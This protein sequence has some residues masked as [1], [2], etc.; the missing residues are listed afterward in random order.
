MNPTE[1]MVITRGCVVTLRYAMSCAGERIEQTEDDEPMLYLHGS[2]ALVPGL[3][4]ALGGRRAGTRLDLVLEPEE[5]FGR[6]DPAKIEYLPRSAFPAGAELELG[7]QFGAED[8]QGNEVAVWITDI[9]GERVCVNGNHPLVD[10][11][12]RFEVEVLAVRPATSAEV[13][14]GHPHEEGQACQEPAADEGA[15]GSHDCGC[16]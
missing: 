8:E 7:M 10:Q 16:H 6:S 15:C 12:L 1:P 14:H 4:L 3:E 9:D 11:T 13:E 5:A 2:G